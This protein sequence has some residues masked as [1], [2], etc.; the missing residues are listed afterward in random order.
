MKTYTLDHGGSARLVV[1]LSVS[2]VVLTALLLLRPSRTAGP[3][4]APAHQII[5]TGALK[6]L[7][8][9]GPAAQAVS[10]TAPRSAAPLAPAPPREPSPETRQLVNSLV[11]VQLTNGV[12]SQDQAAEWQFNLARLAACGPSAIPAIRE[13]LARNTDLDFGDAGKQSV[14]YATARLG[15]LDVLA[16]AGGPDAIGALSDVLQVT[17]DPREIGTIARYLEQLDPGN[18][19][20][21]ALEAARQTLDLATQGNLPDRDVAPIFELFKNYGDANLATELAQN[22]KQWNYYSM[23]ALSQLP[24]GAGIP[25][26]VQIVNGDDTLSS[27]ARVPALE[28][29][30]QAAGESDLARSALVEQARQNKLTEYNWATLQAFLAGDVLRFQDSVFDADLADAEASDQQHTHVNSGN[31]NFYTGPPPTGLTP[32]QIRNRAALIDELMNVTTDPAGQQVLQRAKT[33]LEQRAHPVASTQ[34]P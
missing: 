12:L 11:Q 7:R 22:S 4:P 3:D 6:T 28:M 30:A 34:N 15:L 21:D 23:F 10:E 25:A 32:E 16:K 2:A 19:R 31:Q 9:S 20:Q 29:L 26:L 18:H 8:R 14:G 1:I 13:F 17:G 33:D 27:S 24:E 5:S